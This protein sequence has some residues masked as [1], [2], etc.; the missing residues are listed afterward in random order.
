MHLSFTG[1]ELLVD[2]K[3]IA[4]RSSSVDAN[5]GIEN[6]CRVAEFMEAFQSS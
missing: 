6:A 1:L 2:I 5:K 3:I 4:T